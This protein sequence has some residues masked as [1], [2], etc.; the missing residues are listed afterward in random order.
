MEEGYGGPVWHASAAT[1]GMRLASEYLEA[2]AYDA[3][4]NVGNVGDAGR[5][6][7]RDWTGRAFHLRRRLSAEEEMAVGPVVDVRGT[8]E[9][10]KRYEALRNKL[11]PAALAMARIEL[12]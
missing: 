3:L 8:P 12:S 5:G 9:A 1:T 10:V 2:K 7:W 6:E 4:G 11:P